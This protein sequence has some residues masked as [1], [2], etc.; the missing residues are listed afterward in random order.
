MNMNIS[1]DQYM[2]KPWDSMGLARYS[3]YCI[4]SNKRTFPNKCN[5]TSPKMCLHPECTPTGLHLVIFFFFFF[6]FFFIN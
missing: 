2:Y 5:P 3:T 1:D 6:F 4:F